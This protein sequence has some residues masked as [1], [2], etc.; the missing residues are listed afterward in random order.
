MNHTDLHPP[1]SLAV[2]PQIVCS[3]GVESMA[4][5]Y[6]VLLSYASNPV[7][8]HFKADSQEKE[9]EKEEAS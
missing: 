2:C 4:S 8:L 1:S 3:M 7:Y 9:T 5:P 6:T